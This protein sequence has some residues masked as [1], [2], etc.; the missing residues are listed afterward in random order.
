MSSF[1]VSPQQNKKA[2]QRLKDGH[3][4]LKTQ[5]PLQLM[6]FHA[7]FT[8][9]TQSGPYTYVSVRAVVIAPLDVA[10]T[11][12]GKIQ[13]FGFVVDGESIRGDDIYANNDAE[14]PAG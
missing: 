11:A 2:S 14:V 5:P 7:F 6:H 3:S 13:L 12:V 10:E 9:H 8:S 1:N 4:A